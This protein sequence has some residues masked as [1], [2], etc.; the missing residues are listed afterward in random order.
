MAREG[1]AFGATAAM[2]LAVPFWVAPLHAQT[3]GQQPQLQE[4]EL[5]FRDGSPVVKEFEKR[6]GPSPNLFDALR[7][8]GYDIDRLLDESGKDID[9]LLK[10]SKTSIDVVIE[11]S[12][13]ASAELL[14]AAG[15]DADWLLFR[16]QKDRDWIIEKA[17][18]DLAWLL[19]QA[20]ASA[21]KLLDWA[22]QDADWLLGR[23]GQDVDWVLSRAGRDIPWMLDKA[24]KGTDWVAGKVRDIICGHI[25]YS[26]PKATCKKGIDLIAG[27]LSKL[28]DRAGKDADWW[29]DESGKDVDWLL[30]AI[31]KDADWLL[32]EADKDKVWL[33][34][35]LGKDADWLVG[36]AGRD[37][38]WLLAALEEDTDWLLEKAER[39]RA[40]LFRQLG[41][42]ARWALREL[43]K[44]ADWMLAQ[45][46]WR[47]EEAD[48]RFTAVF[49]LEA[50]TS[51]GIVLDYEGTAQVANAPG[52]AQPWTY[53]RRIGFGKGTLA[54]AEGL[55]A[56]NG[57]ATWTYTDPT[58]LSVSAGGDI[59]ILNQDMAIVLDEERQLH[60]L[61]RHADEWLLTLCIPVGKIIA[62][63][64]VEVPPAA[65]AALLLV[66][67]IMMPI[68]GDAGF[69]LRNEVVDPQPGTTDAFTLGEPQRFISFPVTWSAQAFKDTEIKG[70]TFG[71][72]WGLPCTLGVGISVRHEIEGGQTVF[73]SGPFMISGE[74][75]VRIALPAP[76]GDWAQPGPQP[77]PR[78]GPTT[79][80]ERPVRPDQPIQQP[81]PTQ[82]AAPTKPAPAAAVPRQATR[83]SAPLNGDFSM[84]LDAWRPFSS[85]GQRPGNYLVDVRGGGAI[86]GRQ[87]SNN[88]GGDAGIDQPLD[89]IVSEPT[90]LELQVMVNHQTLQGGGFR[91]GEYPLQ[92]VLRYEDQQGQTRTWRHGFYYLGQSVEPAASTRVTQGRW[93]PYRSPNLARLSPAPRRIN[94]IRV[95][96]NGWD[97]ESRVDNV[98]FVHE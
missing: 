83:V 64:L 35:E 37:T 23:L 61:T 36:Q 49:R 80:P 87:Q 4:F 95:Y 66:P 44:D 18:R 20:D 74:T 17:D 86:L 40:W 68:D 93:V 3:I 26:I 62:A 90:Y 84:G 89:L 11:K 9:W 57:T 65:A 1:A 70:A 82:P 38:A 6:L 15:H 19:V 51:R 39:N 60:E 41:Q 47:M 16:L 42:D 63:L 97:Y 69:W 59:G 7:D 75:T 81:P 8:E 92:V 96:A 50:V 53:L 34:G 55:G 24:D 67:D 14:T 71:F 48:L 88:A 98:R 77:L 94:L 2:F 12:D 21:T 78:P 27:S 58:G 46:G 22:R 56:S 72:A 32:Q 73:E 52:A 25:K 45:L 54:A 76:P 85:K 13:V 10:A 91:G 29:L 28:L 33:L 30:V 43:D 79:L 5:S 31:G